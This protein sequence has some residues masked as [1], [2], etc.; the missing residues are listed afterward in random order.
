MQILID[1]YKESVQNS[2]ELSVH[3]YNLFILSFASLVESTSK[4]MLI[5]LKNDKTIIQDQSK[6]LE[7]IVDLILNVNENKISTK[8]EFL[9]TFSYGLVFKV[10]E[11]DFMYVI[12]Q[13]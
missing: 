3:D 8:N 5:Y 4:F 6:W 13:A 1:S 2:S 12:F 10:E 9:N 7:V 11:L